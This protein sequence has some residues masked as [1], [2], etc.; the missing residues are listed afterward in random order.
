MT[1]DQQICA[2]KVV[3]A[4]RAHVEQ[5]RRFDRVYH[6]ELAMRGSIGRLRDALDAYDAAIARA[7]AR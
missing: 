1:D 2:E 6:K 7:R 5:N 4:A 3:E